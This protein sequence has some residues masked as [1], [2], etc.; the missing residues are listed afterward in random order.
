ATLRD[1]LR[2]TMK[3]LGGTGLSRRDTDSLA[4]Y[5]ESLPTVRTPTRDAAQ[6]ARGRQVFEAEGCRSCHAGPAYTDPP[7][8]KLGG[9]LKESDTPSLLGLAASAPYFHDGS[10]ATLESVLRDRG[11]VHGM[12]D[13]AR[14]SDKDLADLTAFLET[15]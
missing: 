10:A 3:R 15:L 2:S 11:A 4:A 14:L 12:A 7:R 5:L 6:V 9:R 1:S 8:P 13:T